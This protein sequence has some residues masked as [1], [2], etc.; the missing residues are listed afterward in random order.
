MAQQ[1]PYTDVSDL[2]MPMFSGGPDEYGQEIVPP[3][4]LAFDRVNEGRAPKSNAALLRLPVEVL[5]HI[6]GYAPR[7]SLAAFALVNTDCRQ[8]ARSRQFASVLL[9]YSDA[10]LGLIEK[11]LGEGLERRESNNNLTR[12]PSLGAC[13]RRIVSPSPRRVTNG[14]LGSSR[15]TSSQPCFLIISQVPPRLKSSLTYGLRRQSQQVVAGCPAVMASDMSFLNSSEKLKNSKMPV[16]RSS[17]STS[18]E[19]K[20]YFVNRCP[21]LNYWTGKT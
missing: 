6:S 13:I 10:S 11:L 5:G 1:Q 14:C 15:A 3:A 9:D 7:D 19:S 4:P 16:A 21:I 2:L 8:L 12:S 18:Q 20:L 17:N